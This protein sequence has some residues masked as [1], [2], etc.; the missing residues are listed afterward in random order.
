MRDIA[1]V[2]GTPNWQYVDEWIDTKYGI[3]FTH[4]TNLSKTT[5][6]TKALHEQLS[7]ICGH[8]HTQCSIEYVNQA[9]S[10][11]TMF[12]GCGINICSP[13]FAYAKG[14]SKKPILS[15]GVVFDGL[16]ILEQMKEN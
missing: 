1:E 10:L 2:L 3:L 12:V 4:G 16:P 6:T 5:I 8:H 11:F 7:V 14:F 13:A 15:C 9:S